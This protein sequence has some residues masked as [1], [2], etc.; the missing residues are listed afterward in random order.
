[1]THRVRRFSWLAALALVAAL[2]SSCA[3]YN[4][5]YLAKKYYATATDGMPYAVEKV[6]GAQAGN[7]Q[8]SI[9]YSKKVITN[10]PKS[11]HVDDAYLMWA[12]SLLG[13]EDPLQTVNM[14]LDFSPRYPNSQL[15]DEARFYLG[16]AYRQARKYREALVPLEEFLE[17]EPKHELAPYAHL[18]R[19][20][21]LASLNR[22]ADAAAAAGQIVE[23]FPG[24]P[25]L[26]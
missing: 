23:R 16:V 22:H 19:A 12:K 9:D 1:M 14:L 15:K 26:V 2:G 4:T 18:E 5:F 8:K 20:R 11:K 3:Y 7:Y 6:T 13:K 25:L 21:A 10:Y 24:S 17:K